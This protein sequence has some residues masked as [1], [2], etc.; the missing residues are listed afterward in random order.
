VL[1]PNNRDGV[2]RRLIVGVVIGIHEH[3]ELEQSFVL[4]GSAEDHD[5]VATAGD[6][7]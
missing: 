6:Y 5:C 7:I 1:T 4:E 2:A 3:S